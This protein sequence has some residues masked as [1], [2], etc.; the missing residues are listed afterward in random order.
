VI[1]SLCLCPSLKAQQPA[2]ANQVF[3]DAQVQASQQH[4]VIFFVFGASW[5]GPCHRLDDF[6]SAPE[7]RNILEKHFVEAKVNVLEDKGKHPEL[8]SLGAEELAAKLGGTNGKGRVA[9][10]PFIIFL[11]AAGEP[12]INSFR[13]I[14]GGTRH[15]NIGYPAK[16]EEI[17]WFG[18][19]LKKSAPLMSPDELRTIDEWLRKASAQKEESEKAA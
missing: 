15:A 1:F 8:E 13:P 4:K 18:E 9:G 2:S 17:D 11:D 10:V 14:D 7:T 6:L 3:E 16:P 5:C 19:M 12:I